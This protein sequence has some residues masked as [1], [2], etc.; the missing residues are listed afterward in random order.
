LLQQLVD[1]TERMRNEAN[2]RH[3]DTYTVTSTITRAR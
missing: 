1:V 3:A 2:D